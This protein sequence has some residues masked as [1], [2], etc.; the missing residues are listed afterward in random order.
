MAR[1]IDEFLNMP[2]GVHG[3][4]LVCTGSQGEGVILADCEAGLV[5]HGEE[6]KAIAR[7]IVDAHNEWLR[8]K[9]TQ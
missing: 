5:V 9:E 4:T 8:N 3:E 2:W 6:S 7:H 1:K